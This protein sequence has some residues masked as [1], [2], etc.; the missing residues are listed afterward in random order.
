MNKVILIGNTCKEN[1]LRYSQQ[2]I[3]VLSNTIAVNRAGAKNADGS[4][5]S[6]FINFTAF[7][8]QAEFIN[9]YCPKGSKIA[10]EGSWQNRQYQ[11]N[12]GTM[13]YVSE[14]I[15]NSVELIKSSQEAQ[16]QSY[17]QQPSPYQQPQPT[18]KTQAP[19]YQAPSYSNDPFAPDVDTSD[20]PF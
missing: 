18:P 9:Q 11:A 5:V 14:L 16:P 2:G 8:Q 6:D 13:R 4:K 17:P 19:Q 1:E 20:L 12:D 3:A 15:V 7:R 10:L